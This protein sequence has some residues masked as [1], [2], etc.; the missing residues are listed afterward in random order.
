MK[1]ILLIIVVVL[2]SGFIAS[3]YLVWK[4]AIRPN[5]VESYSG[6]II[7]PS[8]S[9]FKDLMDILSSKEILKNEN[10][11]L[12]IAR[13]KKLDRSVKPGSYVLETGMSNNQI[14]NILRSGRQTPVN[15]TF[16][17]IRTLED[18]AGRIGAVIEA[19]S[20]S[21]I[22]FLHDPS[23]YSEDG[24]RTETVISVFIPDTYQ[25]YWTTDA[26]GLYERMLR[27]YRLFWNDERIAS[28]AALDL[29]PVDV[30]TLASII[31]DEVAKND[32]KPRIAGVYLN[33]LRLGIPLQAC[34]TIK[35]ALNDFTIR[36]VLYEHLTVDSPYNTY[37][38]RG[39]PPGPVRCPSKEGI[40]AVL[41]AEKHD[42]LYFAAK[43]DFSGYHHFS[44]TL[45]EHNKYA[46]EYQRELNRKRIYE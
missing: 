29:T 20:T 4:M 5:V 23:N 32:E 31:D 18:L 27:E 25:F 33:R 43:S 9:S 6:R 22:S 11:F 15:V 41:R 26:R 13:V 24:F 12:I 45:A 2:A 37:Q 35:F 1:K 40:D 28:A 42:Y 17:N 8:R 19:D 34:P 46:N 10:T 30:S 36:R 44:R 39:L 38:H 3:A 7:I 14:I 16:N 21:I